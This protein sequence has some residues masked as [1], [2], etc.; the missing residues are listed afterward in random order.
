MP[1]EIIKLEFN[2]KDLMELIA[3]KYNLKLQTMKISITHFKGDA[4]EPS[5]TSIIIESEKKE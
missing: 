5:Y 4:R 2:E 3:E 1:K